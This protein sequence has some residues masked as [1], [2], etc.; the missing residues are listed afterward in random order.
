MVTHCLRCRGD[1]TMKKT[2]QTDV[3]DVDGQQ[4]AT[5]FIKWTT[6]TS[7]R[8]TALCDEHYRLLLNRSELPRR[9]RR[10]GIKTKVTVEPRRRKPARRKAAIRKRP[11]KGKS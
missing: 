8:V 11:A 5:I 2:V 6:G 9:G 1:G 7:S 4:V 3:C 10:P